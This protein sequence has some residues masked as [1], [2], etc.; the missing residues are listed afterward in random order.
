MTEYN[1]PATVTS[2]SSWKVH[3]APNA[4]N[5]VI[6]GAGPV[7]LFTALFLNT[8]YNKKVHWKEFV[9]R[10]VNILLVDNRIKEEG[11]KLPYSRSTQFSFDVL[12]FKEFMPFIS[13]WNDDLTQE[14]Q[15]IFDYIHVLEN[16]LYTYAYHQKI[17]MMFTKQF[18]DYK[19]LQHLVDKQAIHI[20]FDCTGG[21]T[22]IPVTI[23]RSIHWNQYRMKQGYQEIRFNPD[24]KY[25]EY[26]EHGHVYKKP[27]YRI[28]MFDKANKEYL[29]GNW[30]VDVE[31]KEDAVLAQKY[32]GVC[33]T[34]EDYIRISSHFKQLQMRHLF[35]FLT[36]ALHIPL[37]HIQYVK[38]SLFSL[39]ARHS[40]FAATN[41]TK[42]TLLVRLGDA[43]G[44]T[45]YGMSLGMKHSL[46]LSR[47]ICQ[48]LS[49]YL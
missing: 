3:D 48:L 13:C 38:I 49:S 47:H 36:R 40:P 29:S 19:N 42:N 30:L 39:M 1:L 20:V 21:R 25:Y 44:S 7:G 8:Y 15:R 6:L 5:V 34:P 24:T 23:P 9:L 4:I 22:N 33:L 32:N 41:L 43:L 14:D 2:L 27:T 18:D 16:M 17:P 46:E 31:E 12:N 35:P 26:C 11:L 28:Q 37:K 45:E 10:N